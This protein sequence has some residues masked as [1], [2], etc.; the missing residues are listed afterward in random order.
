MKIPREI[1][2]EK[3][4]IT[5]ET[6]NLNITGPKQIGK[7]DFISNLEERLKNSDRYTY[8]IRWDFRT[9]EAI[10]TKLDFLKG[11]A[12]LFASAVREQNVEAAEYYLLCAEDGGQ[13]DFESGTKCIKDAGESIVVLYDDFLSGIRLLNDKYEW[14]CWFRALGH[15]FEK[16][17]LRQVVVTP[18]NID[19]HLQEDAFKEL[20]SDVADLFP[21][22]EKIDCFGD[23]FDSVISAFKDE[24]IVFDVPA[25]KELLNWTGGVPRYVELTSRLIKEQHQAGGTVSQD[26]LN[27]MMKQLQSDENIL[28]L[29]KSL[30]KDC[31]SEEMDVLSIVAGYR[32]KK[33]NPTVDEIGSRVVINT[34][35]SRGFLRREKSKLVIQCRFIWAEIEGAD[36]KWDRLKKLFGDRRS[37]DSA[38]HDTLRIKLEQVR[39]FDEA[40]CE[41][42]RDV[43]HND[44]PTRALMAVREVNTRALEM[45][46]DK[47]LGPGVRKVKKDWV[48]YYRDKHG[49]SELARSIIYNSEIPSEPNDQK[50]VLSHITGNCYWKAAPDPTLAAYVTEPTSSL[51]DF[52]HSVGNIGAHYRVGDAFNRYK[53][54]GARFKKNA[55]IPESYINAIRHTC[56]AL[57]ESLKADFQREPH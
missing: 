42:I 2:T 5:L 16:G 36:W 54:R 48:Q 10:R 27:G 4:L 40:L 26:M 30:L 13:D 51:I 24:G 34:L 32:S 35:C 43:V 22:A 12:T 46:W 15:T 23:D 38:M 3:I 50:K 45:I 18:R 37:F 39:A 6:E 25:Q 20:D 49:D 41:C 28:R 11:L 31:S 7:T 56:L 19:E 53:D 17:V 33:A 52:L 21:N 9:T 14:A 1:L 8:V 55:A 44:N 47:E 57:A 29:T